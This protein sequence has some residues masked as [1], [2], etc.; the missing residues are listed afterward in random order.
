MLRFTGRAG[1]GLAGELPNSLTP[2]QLL[3]PRNIS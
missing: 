1:E 2:A 3:F